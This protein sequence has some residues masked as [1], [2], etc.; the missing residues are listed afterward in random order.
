LPTQALLVEQT[1]APRSG[2]L[3]KLWTVHE[4]GPYLVGRDARG[5]L[6]LRSTTDATLDV[7]FDSRS[8]AEAEAKRR[9]DATS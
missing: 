1:T 5:K 7:V 2:K 4:F 6:H 9:A 8:D 3:V